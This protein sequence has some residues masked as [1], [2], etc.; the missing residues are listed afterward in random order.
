MKR[1]TASM[2]RLKGVWDEGT[3]KVNGQSWVSEEC[4]GAKGEAPVLGSL[5]DGRVI[6]PQ[7]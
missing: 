5:S 3:G 2:K 1:L 4:A 6:I 7:M